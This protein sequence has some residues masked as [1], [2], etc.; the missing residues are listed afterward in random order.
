MPKQKLQNVYKV[1]NYIS[2]K[3]RFVFRRGA[4]AAQHKKLPITRGLTGKNNSF[5]SP[6]PA[7]QTFLIWHTKKILTAPPPP[8]RSAKIFY[9]NFTLVA[10]AS[11][12]NGPRASNIFN[13]ALFKSI[14]TQ[15]ITCKVIF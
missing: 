4:R 3:S 8:P 2:L 5:R 12:H 14:N 7:Q 10:E 9:I 13:T 11:Q 15:Y 6:L 1:H